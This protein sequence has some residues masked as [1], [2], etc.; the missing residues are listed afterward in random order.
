MNQVVSQK[1]KMASAL[2]MILMFGAGFALTISAVYM[3]TIERQPI[4]VIISG[5]GALLMTI[6]TFIA[7]IQQK[8]ER[9]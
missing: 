9:V 2:I 4:H 1:I 3:E 5:I 7:I 6:A 8:I